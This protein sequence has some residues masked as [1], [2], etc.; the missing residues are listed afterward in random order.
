MLLKI[1]T[2]LFCSLTKNCGKGTIKSE[3]KLVI[4]CKNDLLGNC[5]KMKNIWKQKEIYDHKISK[6]IFMMIKC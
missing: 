1:S 5:C 4:L 6:H 2:W 3:T